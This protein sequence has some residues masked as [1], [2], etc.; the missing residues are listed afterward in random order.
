MSHTD[1]PF[2]PLPR[3]QGSDGTD[4]RVGVEIEF[5]GLTEDATAT[6]VR[7]ELGGDIHRDATHDLHVSGTELG[8]VKIVLDTALRRLGDAGPVDKVLDALRGLIPVEIVTDPL[9]RDQLVRLDTFRDTLRRNGAV[10]TTDGV[11]LGFGVHLN[12][13]ITDTHDPFTWQTVLA[14][15]LM[16]GW[17]RRRMPIDGTRR[18]MPFVAP[19]P[20]A[21]VTE[22]AHIGPTP[23]CDAVRD[24]YAQHCNSRNHALDLLPIFRHADTE[25]FDRLF[26]NQ[27]NT[28]GR[29]AFHFRLPDCRIDDAAW[30]LNLEWQRWRLVELLAADADA[31]SALTRKR[32][33]WAA[34]TAAGRPG[35]TDVV[36]EV[37][38][39]DWAALTR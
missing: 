13:S 30:S 32:R 6:L 21:F 35:W 2:A 8:T 36:Q 26:P 10:G 9:T 29:P 39:T 17:L 33:A 16:Q 37:L 11:L 28:K 22:L 18:L 20:D 14:F 38:G 19:W 15:A 4:R 7:A 5:A 25:A 31:L 27:S 23:T 34:Q 3:P 24:L 12:V 1:T